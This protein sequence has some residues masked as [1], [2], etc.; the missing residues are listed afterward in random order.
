LRRF[1]HAGH[2]AVRHVPHG[3]IRLLKRASQTW[4]AVLGQRHARK[5]N[6]KARR[7]TFH[8]ASLSRV[9]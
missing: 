3:Q 1:H 6:A 7:M 2:G 9:T 5:Q 8:A 4:E